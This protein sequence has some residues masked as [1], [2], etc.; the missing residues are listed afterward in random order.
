M[1][2][3]RRPARNVWRGRALSGAS[4]ALAVAAALVY[5]GGTSLPAAVVLGGTAALIVGSTILGLISLFGGESWLAI[6]LTP[7]VLIFD[8]L[9]IF[10]VLLIYG[11]MIFG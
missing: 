8:A 7:A 11:S 3:A 5:V 9:A 1:E 2:T 10:I 6:T 4:A